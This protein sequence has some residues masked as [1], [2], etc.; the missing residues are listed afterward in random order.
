MLFAQRLLLI[1]ATAATSLTPRPAAD[2]RR[3]NATG[4]EVIAAIAWNHLTPAARTK[5]T[6]LLRNGPPE[7]HLGDLEPTSGTPEER[8]RQL[9]IVAST[10]SDQV[11]GRQ[12]PNHAY[13]RGTWHYTD[14]Y[15]KDVNG[16]PVLVPELQPD[17][18]N[19]VERLPV[20]QATLA[21][22]GPDSSRAVALAW[23]EH[24][25]GDIHQPLHA[26]GRVTPDL[27][28]GD[29]GGN[30]FKL[31]GNP[32]NLHAYWDGILD[33]VEPS[34][35]DR[36]AAVD[37]WATTIEQRIPMSS[38]KSADLDAGVDVW[39]KESLELAQRQ[40]YPSSLAEHAVPGDDYKKA[41]DAAAERR[42]AIAGYRLATVL[43]KL[44]K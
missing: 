13:D 32:N 10:W 1:V 39:T 12:A 21:A 2:A 29:R 16:K 7:A 27:P 4:H 35:G 14:Y 25:V 15:W 41:A 9:F 42:I 40:L 23:I 18:E 44:L 30:D 3:W 5:A 31:G 26:S 36:V 19:L 17:P 22:A 43:N 33:L 28:K 38:F 34:N 11:K 37:T 8:A 24:L 6:A 20:L